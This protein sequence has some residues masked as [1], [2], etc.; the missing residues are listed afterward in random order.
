MG[1]EN[2]ISSVIELAVI[3]H[4]IF[5]W[6]SGIDLNCNLKPGCGHRYGQIALEEASS[7]AL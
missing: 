5:L 7:F 4:F 6:Y 3:F 1:E 2:Q